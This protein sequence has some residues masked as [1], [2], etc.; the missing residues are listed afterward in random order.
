M[1]KWDPKEELESDICIEFIDQYGVLDALNQF[2]PDLFMFHVPNERK[3][4][5]QQRVKLAR[6]GVVAGVSDYIIFF[7]NKWAAIEFKRSE[8]EMKKLNEPQ[9][10]FKTMCERHG[11]PYLLTCKEEEAIEFLKSL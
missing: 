2:R 6:M 11:A 10:T 4:S 7:G 3:C 8:K 9:S 1:K 5:V